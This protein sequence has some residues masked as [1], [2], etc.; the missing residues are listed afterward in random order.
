MA[1]RIEKSRVLVVEGRDEE[2]FFT[3]FIDNCKDKL[4]LPDIQILPV[5]GKSRLPGNLKALVKS[6]GFSEI[7]SLG[8]VRDADEDARAAF[9][10]VCS[11]LR[12]AGL[13]AP[14]APLVSAGSNP[15]V[16][17]IILPGDNN[18][19]ML[20]DLCLPFAYSGVKHS[21]SPV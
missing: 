6:P 14:P 17:V 5:G 18:P 10:S 15:S 21:S 13:S 4:N 11:A 19:G 7:I 3:A 2:L 20:E 12:S 8:I 9:Q 1:V 16:S